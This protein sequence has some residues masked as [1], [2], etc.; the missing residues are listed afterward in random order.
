MQPGAEAGGG[1]DRVAKRVAEVEKC[2]WP[3]FTLVGRDDRGFELARAP[4]SVSERGTLA[5]QKRLDVLLEPIKERRV[6][7]ISRGLYAVI[8]EGRWRREY[9]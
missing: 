7:F 8:F 6:I 3:C 1:L 5:R 2:A 9:F 4:Y